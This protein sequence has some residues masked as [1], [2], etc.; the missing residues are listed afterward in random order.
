MRPSVLNYEISNKQIT[1]EHK[2]IKYP[3]SYMFRHYGVNIR[4]AFRTYYKTCMY[5][6]V[7]VTSHFL[8]IYAMCI[9]TLI[10]SKRQPVDDPIVSK[11]V[12]VWILYE[13]VFD[14]YLFTPY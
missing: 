14:G 4:L 5:C 10:C 8:Q 12:A 2:F 7:E 6:I 11:H 3:Y 1:I 9:L 13:V